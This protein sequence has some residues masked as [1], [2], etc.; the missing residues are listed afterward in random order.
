MH[1]IMESIGSEVHESKH[2]SHVSKG[3]WGRGGGSV[4]L[5]LYQ[6]PPN[7]PRQPITSLP[8]RFESPNTRNNI[9]KQWL[10]PDDRRK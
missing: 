2:D 3:C 5:V 6:N 1:E 9:S 8:D 7:W 4:E 10:K